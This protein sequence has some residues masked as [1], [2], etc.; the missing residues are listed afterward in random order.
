M[1]FQIMPD[2]ADFKIEAFTFFC[3]L[4]A[5][6]QLLRI[7]SVLLTQ[8]G[9]PADPVVDLKDNIVYNKQQE[10]RCDGENHI[11]IMN[12]RNKEYMVHHINAADWYQ[13]NAQKVKQG[14]FGIVL[15]LDAVAYDD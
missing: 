4:T 2:S 14:D 6:L 13:Q 10:T 1:V 3:L 11:L 15:I 5:K 12:S 7:Q 9:V 8:F